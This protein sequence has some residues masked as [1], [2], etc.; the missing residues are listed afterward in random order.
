MMQ[1]ESFRISN[2]AYIQCSIKFLK[3]L[4]FLTLRVYAREMKSYTRMKLILF[5]REFHPG[6][7][8]VEFHP[9]MILKENLLLSMKTYNKIHNFF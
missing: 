8:G 7:K 6:M 1:K 9:G 5:L 3:C 4:L 2:D